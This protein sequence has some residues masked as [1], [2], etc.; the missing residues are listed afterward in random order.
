MYTLCEW[1]DDVHTVGIICVRNDAYAGIGVCFKLFIIAKV[2]KYL[3]GK[4]K[5]TLLLPLTGL[6][7]AGAL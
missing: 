6:A 2:C 1:C 4:K 5:H 3:K 7:A